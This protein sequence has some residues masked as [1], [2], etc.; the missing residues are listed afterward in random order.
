MRNLVLAGT[1]AASWGGAARWHHR[2]LFEL[3]LPRRWRCAATRGRARRRS[4]A[5]RLALTRVLAGALRERSARLRPST[6]DRRLG[7]RPSP[8]SRLPVRLV[9]PVRQTAFA[10]ARAAP[11][12]L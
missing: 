7:D 1:W 10:A 3:A 9:R 6:V 12:P 2:M 4:R 8:R 11:R 5:W